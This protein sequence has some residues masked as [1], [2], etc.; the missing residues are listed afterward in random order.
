MTR[1][2]TTTT[3][4]AVSPHFP[5][6]PEQAGMYEVLY[7][8]PPPHGRG[9]ISSPHSQAMP[10]QAGRDEVLYPPPWEG[11]NIISILFLLNNWG[12]K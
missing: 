1:R 10:E 4:A 3:W 9:I 11:I 2:A 12:R 7:P 5:A 6:M 8:R